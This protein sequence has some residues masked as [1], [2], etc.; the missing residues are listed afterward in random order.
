MK[1]DWKAGTSVVDTVYTR[2]EQWAKGDRDKFPGGIPED[3]IHIGKHTF[4]VT[5]YVGE[6]N[7]NP[8]IGAIWRLDEKGIA[9][10]VAAIG[11]IHMQES[12]HG[13]WN[14]A[15]NPGVARY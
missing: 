10:P 3:A 8:A 11:G 7:G 4:L 15:R 2:P 13:S 14:A 5:N 1:L 12:T 9:W 6:L